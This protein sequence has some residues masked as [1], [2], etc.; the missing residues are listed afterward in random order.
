MRGTTIGYVSYA[1]HSRRVRDETLDLLARRGSLGSCVQLYR[2]YGYRGTL[3]FLAERCG[4]LKTPEALTGAID[5]LDASRAV[6]L[7]ELATFAD[8]RRAAKAAGHRQPTREELARFA[9][10]GWPGYPHDSLP[11]ATSFLHRFGLTL[12]D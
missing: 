6:W 1:V 12:A 4:R 11:V 8:D 7:S 9:T 2:P 5:L 3:V 10:M